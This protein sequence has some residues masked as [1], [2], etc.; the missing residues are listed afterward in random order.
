MVANYNQLQSTTGIGILQPA[1]MP[2]PETHRSLCP[3]NLALEVFGDR[4]TLLIIRDLMFAGKRHFRELLQSDERIASNILAD[5]LNRLVDH[6]LVTRSGDPSHKQKAVY[7]LTDKGIDLLPVLAQMGI[8]SRSHL[9]V[10]PELGA[11][12]AELEAGG[13]ALWA[14]WMA[15]LRAE[16]RPA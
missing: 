4:W 7:S 16:H 9:P 2:Q 11:T 13:P 6:G 10:S 12:A 3:I 14:E 8:W 1:G 15:R 5:R